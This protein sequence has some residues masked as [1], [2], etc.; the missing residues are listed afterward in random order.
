M[1][2]WYRLG[3]GLSDKLKNIQGCINARMNDL[4]KKGDKEAMKTYADTLTEEQRNQARSHLKTSIA[5][6][7]KCERDNCTAGE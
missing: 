1:N 5:R 2:D 3:A 7:K 4:R 6:E